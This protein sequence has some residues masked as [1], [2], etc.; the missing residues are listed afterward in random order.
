MNRKPRLIS[1]APYRDRVV[2]HALTGI[3]EPICER[4]F[5][6]DSFACRKGKGTHAA[7]RRCQQFA[8]RHRWA[9][10]ADVRKFFPSIDHAILKGLIRRKIKDP[11]V[12]W[13]TDLLIDHSNPQE[14]VYFLF[15]GDD[16]FAPAEHRRG[17][18]LGNQTSQFFANVYL[19][20][21][22]HFVKERLRL[23]GYIRYVDDFVCFADDKRLLQNARRQIADFLATL[24]LKVHATKDAIFP[25]RQGIRFVGYRVWGSHV[26]LVPA[27]VYRFRRRLRSLQEQYARPKSNGKRCGHPWQAGSAMPCRPIL[28]LAGAVVPGTSVPQVGRRTGCCGVVRSTINRRTSASPTATTIARPT[29]TIRWACVP[30]ALRGG[31]RVRH[32]GIRGRLF[33]LERA[34]VQSPG[35]RPVPRP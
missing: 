26:K 1:A 9:Y 32:A 13:L 30:P 19:D 11:H 29:V 25:V 14:E 22:D 20:P 2:H 8:R 24:R 12:L 28:F 3:L 4:S 23:P 5:L 34:G 18:P 35:G 31:H 10:K 17:L 21:L 6:A 33:L 7:M 15:P 27:N 16:F